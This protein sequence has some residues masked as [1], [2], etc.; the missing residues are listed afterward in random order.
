MIRA[1]ISKLINT[2]GETCTVK[3]RISRKVNGQTVY[4]YREGYDTKGQFLQVMPYDIVIYEF[5]N[6]MVGDYIGT[7]LPNVNIK[8][9]DIVELHGTK[10]EVQNVMY[11]RHKGKI[12]YVEVLLRRKEL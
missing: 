12:V 3:Q 6:I 5:G 7:F 8:E 1:V 2:Y 10:L 4:E 11:R 9:G